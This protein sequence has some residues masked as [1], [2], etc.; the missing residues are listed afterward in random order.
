MACEPIRQSLDQTDALIAHKIFRFLSYCRIVH[1]SFDV[2][3]QVARLLIRPEGNVHRQPLR[4]RAF[5]FWNSDARENL[6]LFD[7]NF[8]WE[9]MRFIR[10]ARIL[11][12]NPSSPII[13]LTIQRGEAIRV[14]RRLLV[15]L[16]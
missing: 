6:K 10:H 7:V 4:I 8:V 1:G 15:K 16:L 14:I 2:V 9:R 3:G 12:T 11:A 13:G 5:F